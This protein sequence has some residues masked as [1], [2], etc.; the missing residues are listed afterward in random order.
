M[1][2][3]QGF[4]NIWAIVG[5]IVGIL[6]GSWLTTR[7]QSR[8]WLLDNKRS[9]YRELLTTI[10]DA[11]SK[12]LVFWGRNPVVASGEEQF[13]IGETARQSVDVIYNRL[14]ISDEVKKLDVLK[15][16]ETAIDELRKS[17]N[18]DVFGKSMD[19]IMDDIRSA[20]LADFE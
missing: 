20:A 19:Q 7:N 8:H 5:P 12:L 1:S 17:R 10:A 6:L 18:V 2:R 11:G 16:W 14:F 13:M 4:L 3:F 15:R 9:E